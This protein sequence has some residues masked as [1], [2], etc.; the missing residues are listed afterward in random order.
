[1]S[2]AAPK[3]PFSAA[4]TLPISLI[5]AAPVAATASSTAALNAASSIAFGK[6]PSMTTI[7]ASSFAANSGRFPCTY[8]TTDSRRDFTI[9]RS[10]PTTSSSGTAVT[11]FGRA[12]I[13][14]SFN[15][16]SIIRNVDVRGASPAF[17]DV[18]S[19]SVNASRSPI[20]A[21]LVNFFP[22]LPSILSP[23]IFS[24]K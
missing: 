15:F 20:F 19:A 16:A 3:V 2:N 6:N 13:S 21:I 18:F 7:S 22:S 10:M 12:A 24:A 8:S 9:P 4:I 11:P 17:I 23:E 5:E 1:M 14:R